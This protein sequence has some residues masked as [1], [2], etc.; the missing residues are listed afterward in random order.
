MVTN[1]RFAMSVMYA[2]INVFEKL[3]SDLIDENMIN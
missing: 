3:E 2:I 1:Q